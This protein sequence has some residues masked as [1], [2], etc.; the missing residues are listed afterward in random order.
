MEFGRI[1]HAQLKKAKLTLPPDPEQTTRVLAKAKKNPN[2]KSMW[3]LPNGAVL[4]GLEK[5]IRRE[6][7]RQIF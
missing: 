3:V 4:I 6:P 7:R 5:F 2:Q 1:E